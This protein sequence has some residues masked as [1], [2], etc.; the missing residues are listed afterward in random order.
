MDTMFNLFSSKEESNTVS[1]EERREALATN[2]TQRAHPLPPGSLAAERGAAAVKEVTALGVAQSA[3]HSVR[4]D[5][6]EA[7]EWLEEDRE[8][9]LWL[10]LDDFITH[11]IYHH[12]NAKQPTNMAHRQQRK[13][14]KK[15]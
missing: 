14:K 1:E 11:C 13:Q 9:R 15:N 2:G 12:F 10:Q 5:G 3:Y 7:Q 4:S 8:R 6:Q